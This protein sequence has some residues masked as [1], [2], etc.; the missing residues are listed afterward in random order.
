MG[1]T[2]CWNRQIIILFSVF[3]LL[4]DL[5][6]R[7]S[8]SAQSTRISHPPNQ[9]IISLDSL[10]SSKVL[11]FPLVSIASDTHLVKTVTQHWD[12]DNWVDK[13]KETFVFNSDN[14]CE[15][16][17]KYD[18]STNWVEYSRESYKY[19]PD[20][21]LIETIQ[22]Y[23]TTTST[24]VVN[25]KY[26]YR[27]N[28]QN[29]LVEKIDLQWNN[30][31]WNNSRRYTYFYDA[32]GKIQ[33][34]LLEWW[35]NWTGVNK[36]HNFLKTIYSYDV[37]K[38]LI[39]FLTQRWENVWWRDRDKGMYKY[40]PNGNLFEYIQSHIVINYPGGWAPE[41]RESYFYDFAY[42]LIEEI[43]EYFSLGPKSFDPLIKNLF[44]YDE[45]DK[46]IRKLIKSWENNE[47][48]DSEQII[49]Y[50][51]DYN[52]NEL[53]YSGNQADYIIIT[54]SQFNES[55]T[56]YISWRQA[57]QSNVKIVNS[58][59]I[60]TEFDDNSSNHES[61]REF[62]SYTQKQWAEPKPKF[63]LLVG[64]SDILPTFSIS[65]FVDGEGD[66]PI[67][68]WFVI[69]Q[70]DS[71]N[72]PDVAIGRW[73]ITNETELKN[74]IQKTIAFESGSGVS[75]T[76]QNIL[77]LNDED[78]NPATKTVFEDLASS[79]I[80]TIIP[81][82]FHTSRIDIRTNSPFHDS[83]QNFIS[84]INNGIGHLFYYGHGTPTSWSR[85][86]YLSSDDV[87]LLEQNNKPF[88]L[89]TMGCS[90]DFS[91]PDEKSLLEELLFIPNGGAVAT[92]ASPGYS[93]YITGS[94]FF[95]EIY[96]TLF[97]NKEK[98]IGEII[99]QVKREKYNENTK[100][101]DMT[102][103]YTL[104]GDP[105]LRIPFDLITK[106]KESEK[107]IPSDYALLANYPNP[108]NSSTTIQYQLKAATHVDI[109]IFDIHGRKIKTLKNDRQPAGFH[110]L[111]WNGE[112]DSQNLNSSGQ[113]F[114]RFKA[115]D[116]Q[117][118]K[119]ILLIK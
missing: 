49:Y 40:D 78:T 89:A 4:G 80:S 39:E 76:L 91:L 12:G 8:V 5:D 107:D 50:Y 119:K 77:F 109:S 29:Y 85:E 18:A 114:V 7:M 67:D 20:K 64:D 52:E 110:S 98:S 94:N 101:D 84:Q 6:G 1:I 81:P 61:I 21:N 26:L 38:N 100:A 99:L 34:E 92:L 23:R 87:S 75:E 42:N 9:V 116:F 105:A 69:N 44:Y 90:Q 59:Q 82:K 45:N 104:L 16:F 58:E 97:Q 48:V 71:D 57:N 13:N 112:N 66:V 27:Y 3:F 17:I 115:D 43:K 65:S 53:R 79:F 68:E 72:L 54:P 37:H 51:N 88:F 35:V 36:W 111:N 33:E 117:Q 103:R 73:P 25:R 15:L 63:V 2:L 74:I 11:H 106:I 113:Y 10:F 22:Q 30:E 118:G 19:D 60:L 55:L 70:F 62:I 31:E 47:W 95:N 102:R 28:E 41:F 86:I 24:R 93:S 56:K 96:S 32:D 108:F 14:L 83:K 46:L